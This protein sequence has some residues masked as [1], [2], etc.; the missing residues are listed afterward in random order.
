MLEK[1]IQSDPVS[2]ARA[3]CD[4]PARLR[5]LESFEGTTSAAYVRRI[6]STSRLL[7]TLRFLPPDSGAGPITVKA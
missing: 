3:Y 6:R 5:P 1:D 2:D 7:Q 4:R